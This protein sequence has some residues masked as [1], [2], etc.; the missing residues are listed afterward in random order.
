MFVSV[1]THALEDVKGADPTSQY[2]CAFYFREGIY[3]DSAPTVLFRPELEQFIPTTGSFGLHH[4]TPVE[5]LACGYNERCYIILVAIQPPK[6]GKRPADDVSFPELVCLPLYG[7]VEV[8]FRDVLTSPET[9]RVERDDANE[10]VYALNNV[11]ADVTFSA[12]NISAKLSFSIEITLPAAEKHKLYP[13]RSSITGIIFAGDFS[14]VRHVNPATL[15]G[16]GW[17]LS[18]YLPGVTES[19]LIVFRN[20]YL[21]YTE[22]SSAADGSPRQ[23]PIPTT[24][25]ELAAMVHTG[26]YIIRFPERLLAYDA[27]SIERGLQTVDKLS[28][29]G[30]KG[31]KSTLDIP[32]TLNTI[33]ATLTD[34][35]H[36]GASLIVDKKAPAGKKPDTA[37]SDTSATYGGPTFQTS[38][39][40]LVDLLQMGYTNAL[41]KYYQELAEKQEEEIMD[42]TKTPSGKAPPKGKSQH[43]SL[44]PKN[45]VKQVSFTTEAATDFLKLPLFI[46][47]RSNGNQIV[48]VSDSQAVYIRNSALS[49]MD[50]AIRAVLELDMLTENTPMNH[51]IQDPRYATPKSEQMYVMTVEDFTSEIFVDLRPHLV[52]FN[53]CN[54]AGGFHLDLSS[55][56]F[57]YTE[58][59][60]SLMS[61]QITTA[62][63]DI[64]GL[65]NGPLNKTDATLYQTKLAYNFGIMLHPIVTNVA[66][67]EGVL[68]LTALPLRHSEENIL[69]SIRSKIIPILPLLI[70]IENGRNVIGGTYA[71][72]TSTFIQRLL[73]DNVL[74]PAKEDCSDE[75]LLLWEFSQTIKHLFLKS[76]P[77]SINSELVEVVEK[78]RSDYKKICNTLP[79]PTILHAQLSLAMKDGYQAAREQQ[80]PPDELLEFGDALLLSKTKSEARRAVKLF[81]A[82][83]VRERAQLFQGECTLTLERAVEGLLRSFVFLRNSAGITRSLLR[84]F[85]IVHLRSPDKPVGQ[86][87]LSRTVLLACSE[88]MAANED[89]Y[90]LLSFLYSAKELFTFDFND[91]IQGQATDSDECSHS[92]PDSRMLLERILLKVI[93]LQLYRSL[94]MLAEHSEL[95]TLLIMKIREACTPDSP[96][97]LLNLPKDAHDPTSR[98]YAS[99][100]YIMASLRLS[101]CEY[102]IMHGSLV[103]PQRILNGLDMGKLSIE[104]LVSLNTKRTLLLARCAILEGRP[105]DAKTLLLRTELLTQKGAGEFNPLTIFTELQYGPTTKIASYFDLLNPDL[106]ATTPGLLSNI[107]LI[108]AGTHTIP[109]CMQI[110]NLQLPRLVVMH[111][112]RGD[113]CNVLPTGAWGHSSIGRS[114]SRSLYSDRRASEVL[115][116]PIAAAATKPLEGIP[117]N[118]EVR[119]VLM[120][121]VKNLTFTSIIFNSRVSLDLL[122][123]AYQMYKSITSPMLY[124]GGVL[125]CPAITGYSFFA[126]SAI[127]LTLLRLAARH[128]PVQDCIPF[129]VPFES[130]AEDEFMVAC[131]V[132]ASIRQSL[133]DSG[134]DGYG[135]ATT[136]DTRP[137]LAS[138]YT[139][140]YLGGT[141]PQSSIEIARIAESVGAFLIKNH[142]S[143]ISTRYYSSELLGHQGILMLYLGDSNGLRVVAK[144]AELDAL[145]FPGWCGLSLGLCSMISEQHNGR[146]YRFTLDQV[147]SKIVEVTTRMLAAASQ[148]NIAPFTY[149]YVAIAQSLLDTTAEDTTLL[150]QCAMKLLNSVRHDIPLIPLCENIEMVTRVS[151]QGGAALT[152]SWFVNR[153]RAL[154]LVSCGTL[155]DVANAYMDALKGI[156]GLLPGRSVPEIAERVLLMA[157]TSYSFEACNMI[158][159]AEEV[160]N[161]GLTRLR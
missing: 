17:R 103:T 157:E 33:L 129:V 78:Y 83:L 37:A 56:P 158:R 153:L 18:I 74:P 106:D 121:D 130:P 99:D 76:S 152:S 70:Q 72:T 136:Q 119:P 38:L 138:S 144:A 13:I 15:P 12:A 124:Y 11:S 147:R 24:A 120:A 25:A 142:A 128:I 80:K 115:M 45:Q 35:H 26:H 50:S 150:S 39:T 108:G 112:L 23:R 126:D 2:T 69:E 82:A 29:V 149:A 67:V 117:S 49:G 132:F 102:L 21:E 59:A 7:Y 107:A 52:D 32:G 28:G 93:C 34:T 27:K 98:S 85:S 101:L 123:Q 14:N 133:A 137:S 68:D 146:V 139:V 63:A 104:Q 54:R 4:P 3:L 6:K 8:D 140:D 48:F 53:G 22:N 161:N 135:Q 116:A 58:E 110:D 160:M 73:G 91:C 131:K 155:V 40:A 44:D 114:G 1:Q 159:Q 75:T 16:Y 134:N 148:Q 10:A 43:P 113:F 87:L 19:P 41:Q 66:T 9:T 55:Q 84:V 92:I 154:A 47:T 86:I 61:T 60:L 42:P 65:G 77:G 64:K 71:I 109:A 118:M 143:A 81:G 156:G 90:I 88:L 96:I 95:Q 94:N 30:E 5:A 125:D 145:S 151:F 20:G 111:A 62:E 105:A 36:I 51:L 100:D 46:E 57:Q 122:L 89:D 97:C 79:S 127:C 141:L 31:A